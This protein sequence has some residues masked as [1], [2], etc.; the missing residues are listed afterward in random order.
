MLPEQL[1]VF[2]PSENRG[3]HV[4][5]LLSPILQRRRHGSKQKKFG[6]LTIFFRLSPGNRGRRGEKH[7]KQDKKSPE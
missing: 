3:G 5:T 2:A 7:R 6:V 4:S 1:L